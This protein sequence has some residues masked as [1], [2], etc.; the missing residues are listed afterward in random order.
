MQTY[1]SRSRVRTLWVRCMA[2][3]TEASMLKSLL[4]AVGMTPRFYRVDM[5]MEQLLDSLKDSPQ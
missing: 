5:M 4:E 3:W 2:H 1:H